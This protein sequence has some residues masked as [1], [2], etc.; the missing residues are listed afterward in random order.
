MII[1]TDIF[2][3]DK[4][5]A[6]RD[7]YEGLCSYI[8][9]LVPERYKHIDVIYH[10]TRYYINMCVLKNTSIPLEK[11][12]QISKYL[13]KNI[14]VVGYTD[15]YITC[16]ELEKRINMSKVNKYYEGDKR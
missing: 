15:T 13:T 11:K 5:I 7:D 4:V 12:L 6:L 1:A 10:N 9:T 14:R 8:W 3:M 16:S 2:D